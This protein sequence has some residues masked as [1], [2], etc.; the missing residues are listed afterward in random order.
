VSAVGSWD[1]EGKVLVSSV[2]LFVRQWTSLNKTSTLWNEKY[3]DGMSCSPLCFS[4][5]LLHRVH[6]EW[7]WPL[8]GVHSIMMEKSAQSESIATIPPF[9]PTEGHKWFDQISSQWESQKNRFALIYFGK[10]FFRVLACIFIKLSTS[11]YCT[12][13][14]IEYSQHYP[15]SP[16]QGGDGFDHCIIHG[17]R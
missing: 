7:Q 10:I 3:K 8:F 17:M 4:L 11:N 12:H 16:P 13:K 5:G 6:T 2:T 1:A 14:I 9:G 15:P